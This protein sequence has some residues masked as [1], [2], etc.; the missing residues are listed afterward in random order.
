MKAVGCFLLTIVFSQP[1]L[2]QKTIVKSIRDKT[3]SAINI[4][5]SNCY[6]IEVNTT[7]GDEIKVDA[8]L[9]GEY[10]KDLAVKML[11]DGN[12]YTVKSGF[13]P[14]FTNPNDK[15]SAH[16]VVSIVLKVSLPKELKVSVFGTSC[17]VSATGIYKELE[18]SLSDGDCMLKEVQG[19]VIVKTQSGDVYLYARNGRVDAASKYG[20]V[21]YENQITASNNQYVLSSV[22]G[23]IYINKTE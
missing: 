10:S 1:L 6:A 21:D 11:H 16:K 23:N 2:A 14:L 8:A 13:Q 19:R 3:I 15:L 5:A 20:K 22:T 7:E 17:D 4:D 18:V 9:D 12:T